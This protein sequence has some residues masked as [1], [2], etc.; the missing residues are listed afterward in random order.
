MQSRTSGAQRRRGI[1]L[2]IVLIVI[3]VLGILAGGFAY[4]MKV[5]TTLA[6][7]ASFTSELEWMGRSG[8]EVAKWVLS[9]G[10][11]GQNATFDSLKQK[12]AGGMG[13]TNTAL[14]DI[15][16]K[17]YPIYAPDG[18]IKGTLSIEIED[19]DRK[20]NINRADEVI[21]RQALTLIGV[22]AGSMTTIVSSILDWRDVDTNPHA[23]GTESSVYE[24]ETPPYFA[25]DGPID[26][27]SELLLIRGIKENPNVYFGSGG[28]HLSL[29]PQAQSLRR[30]S[31]SVFEE[32]TY[33]VGLNDLFTAL[34]G[35]GI[36]INTTSA[37]VLQLIPV[38]DENI[39]QAIIQRRAGPDGQDGTE[40]DMPFHTPAEIMMG[41]LLGGGQANP[42]L[43][44]FMS[45]FTVK[46]LV[47]KVRVT[48]SI[49]SSKRTYVAILRRL[50]AKD[51]Q[52]LNLYWE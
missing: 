11:Q 35:P 49:A 51:I 15:D 38:I 34:S 50:N 20:F 22:D 45:M 2:I 46:S 16:L 19:L 13:D 44:Q 10:S 42:A 30:A 36:N 9:Q 48:A 25:K 40:D 4:S 28:G 27:M 29:P 7:H 6:R 5:E 47:F 21:L 39:A 24:Q 43:Q 12:W 52:T 14:S 32:P 41:P 26:D 8:V 1:A 3:V 37:T 23:S 17:N 33:A 31:G 18:S